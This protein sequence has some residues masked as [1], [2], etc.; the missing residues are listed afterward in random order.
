MVTQEKLQEHI[1]NA[2]TKL[3]EKTKV[4]GDAPGPEVKALK[5]KVRRLARK[6]AKMKY[7]QKKADEKRQSKKG[8]AAS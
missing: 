4:A 7:A 6:S 3:S 8:K 5:K 2:K 1:K